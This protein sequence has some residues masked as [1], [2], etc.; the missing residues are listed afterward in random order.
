MRDWRDLKPEPFSSV[1]LSVKALKNIQK[2]AFPKGAILYCV[3][4][5]G[6]EKEKSAEEMSGYLKSW[7]KM[8]GHPAGVKPKY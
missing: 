2:L 7:P 8:H 5:C 3:C 6:Y 1:S 4:G